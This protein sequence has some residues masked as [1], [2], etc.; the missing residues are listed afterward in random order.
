VY[1]ACKKYRAFKTLN[2]VV[3]PQ[4]NVHRLIV[5]KVKVTLK[6]A[7]KA[8]R[9]NRGIALL[10]LITSALD[11]GGWSTPRIGQTYSMGI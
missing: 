6:Q 3:K 5:S 7:M 10:F 2:F 1:V 11:G 4:Q 8:H 9:G